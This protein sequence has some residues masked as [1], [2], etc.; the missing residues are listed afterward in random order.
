[1]NAQAEWEIEQLPEGERADFLADLGVSEPARDRFVRAGYDLLRLISF[2]TVGEDEV[3]AWTIERGDT[4]VR[5]AGKVHSDM[6]RGFIRAEVI[7]CEEFFSLG[8]MAAARKAGALRLEGRDYEVADGDILTIR[9]S[10]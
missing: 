9:F 10:V 2:F 5:A 3:R 7:A 8:S 4:A 6:E 1:M